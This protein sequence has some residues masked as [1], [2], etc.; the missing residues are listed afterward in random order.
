MGL[1]FSFSGLF[2]LAT[3][4]SAVGA[5]PPAAANPAAGG[6]KP[7]AIAV[8]DDSTLWRNV[9]VQRCLYVRAADGKLERWEYTLKTAQTPGNRIMEFQPAASTAPRATPGPDWFGPAFDDSA[10]PRVR[11]PQPVPVDGRRVGSRGGFPGALLVRGEFEVQDPAQ[12]KACRLSLEYWGGLV[13]YVNG[14]EAARGHLPPNQTGEE[15]V[16]EDYLKEAWATPE[17][18]PLSPRDEANADRL[19]LRDRRLEV[20][21]PARLL[22][23]GVNV[24]AVEVVGAP[25]ESRTFD[26]WREEHSYDWP[27]I[28]LLSAKLTVSPA[29]V[30]VANVPPPRGIRVWNCTSYE[31]VTSF[32]YGD[33]TEPLRPI[34]VPAARN[35]AFSGRLVVGSDRSI[36]GLKVSVSDLK[37]AGGGGRI[38]A[39]AVRVRWAVPATPARS[40]VPPGRFDGLSDD[41]PTE[42]PVV[43]AVPGSQRF[44]HRTFRQAELK[45]GAMAPLWF[46]VRVPKDAPP[47]VY[48]GEVNVSAEG[49]APMDV[50]LRVSVSAWTT[51]DPKNFR[52]HNFAHHSPGTMAR[53][54]GVPLWSDKHLELMGK[55]LALMA[56]AGSRQVNANLTVAYFGKGLRPDSLVRWIKRPDGGYSH[57]FTVFDKYLDMVAKYVGEPFP[58]QLNCWR[59]P[60]RGS[61]DWGGVKAASL[62]DPVAAQQAASVGMV[63]LLDPATGTMECM[64]QPALGTE[65]SYDFWRPVF[66][67]ILKKLKARGWLKVTAIAWSPVY[68]GVS[69]DVGDVG[70]RLWPDC[71]WSLTS[72][73][74]LIQDALF[75][76]GYHSLG[77][78]LGRPTVRGYRELLK[79]R[80]KFTTLYWGRFRGTATL[81]DCRRIVEEKIMTGHDGMA[82]FGA[83]LFPLMNDQGRYFSEAPWP[84]ILKGPLGAA[85]VYPGPDGPVAT[86]RYEMFREGVE[87]CE[88]LLF[89]ERAIKDK[90]LGP[91]LHRRAKSHLEDRS[92]AII[93]RW[94]AMGE[95]LDPEEDAKLL[96]LA[97]E[98]AR[99]CDR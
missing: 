89:I 98:V 76:H 64:S 81:S 91:E 36:K 60:Q 94:F 16:A 9:A 40:W 54:Y 92:N 56:E 1:A 70:R 44:Y 46:T 51:P 83:D 86:E 18:S 39:S 77:P 62:L 3:S 29:G 79:P 96:D 49:L 78:Y 58:L 22:R 63:L 20:G 88:A 47:G 6:A 52:V 14:K 75:L 59:P 85:K 42:I 61:K 19:A 41:I 24:L 37:R 2:A 12:V 32:D 17:G 67:E 50:P 74:A 26:D 82:H 35:G 28:G 69:E 4:V 8:L 93:K 7:D 25:V 27:P 71:V 95:M 13:V 55:S 23:R 66:D 33:P 53:Y 84:P 15:A 45:A 10:W 57:D 87:L 21:I 72:H 73:D 97:G 38:P 90:K 99:A 43:D 5:D 48:A 11:L 68:G 80:E 34:V 30:A 65:E 31:T